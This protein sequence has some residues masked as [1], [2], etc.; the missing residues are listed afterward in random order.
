MTTKVPLVLFPFSDCPPDLQRPATPEDIEEASRLMQVPA[1][2]VCFETVLLM[3]NDDGDHLIQE[4]QDYWDFFHSRST[5]EKLQRVTP[6]LTSVTDY[7][8]RLGF[9]SK[10]NGQQ[11]AIQQFV[12]SIHEVG[13]PRWVVR[14]MFLRTDK[15]PPPHLIRPDG[16][17]NFRYCAP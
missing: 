6:M 12:K 10:G 1:E 15:P 3:P 7:T 11:T 16:L 13:R 4:A 2:D 17:G 9:G 8:T 5:E 14:V